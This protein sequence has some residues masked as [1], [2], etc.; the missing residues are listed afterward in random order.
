MQE[1]GFST[2]A[3][4]LSSSVGDFVVKNTEYYSREF[5]KIQSATE[6]PKSWNTMAAVAGPFWGAARGLWGYFWTFM[7]LEI[8]AFVQIG[9]GLWGELGAAQIA[10]IDK[11]APK[12]QSFME[13]YEAALAAGTDDAAGFLSRAENLQ[14]VADRLAEEATA[15]ASGATSYLIVGLAFIIAL[16]IVQA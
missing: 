16:R 7:V 3:N 13:K 8:L 2:N 6:F 11:I 14:K 4:H 12:I 1:S 10:R 5:E 9:K 15:A